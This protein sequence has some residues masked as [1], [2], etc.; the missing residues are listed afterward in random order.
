[1]NFCSDELKQRS[2]QG[3]WAICLSSRRTKKTLV[4][5][6]NESFANLSQNFSALLFQDSQPAQYLLE[7]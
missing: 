7:R 4:S 6:G 1:M 3:R 2:F 5:P